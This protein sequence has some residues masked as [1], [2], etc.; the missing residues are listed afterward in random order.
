MKCV[1]ILVYV[2]VFSGGSSIF[3]AEAPTHTVTIEDIT[4]KNQY[5]TPKHTN[6][7]DITVEG[8]DGAGSSSGNTSQALIVPSTENLLEPYYRAF[9]NSSADVL[10]AIATN[11]WPSLG[12]EKFA[13]IVFSRDFLKSIKNPGEL[14]IPLPPNKRLML[15]R[16]SAEDAPD[17][18]QAFVAQRMPNDIQQQIWP[19]SLIPE[20][21]ANYYLL[22]KLL[23]V[24]AANNLHKPI[25]QILK[26]LDRPTRS[27]Q[28]PLDDFVAQ[29][30]TLRI[31]DSI[32][33]ELTQKHPEQTDL[34]RKIIM[35]TA[36]VMQ[37]N[38][39]NRDFDPSEAPYIPRP[40]QSEELLTNRALRTLESENP[41]LFNA[42]KASQDQDPLL[43]KQ[44]PPVTGSS[45]QVM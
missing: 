1:K 33:A 15:G 13:R 17:N 35:R 7:L 2:C 37:N 8:D 14:Q 36:E 45:C 39:P 4:N 5:T 24:A 43:L 40:R 20:V 30:N 41:S 6:P 21:Y 12:D 34:L 38:N 11:L 16:Y 22:Q 19:E 31:F 28:K 44:A 26:I 23:I 9:P 3:C 25:K 10:S 18:L 27:T 32:G 42:L 29:N